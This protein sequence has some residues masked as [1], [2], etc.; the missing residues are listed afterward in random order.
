M[1]EDV[2]TAKILIVSKGLGDLL[3]A[4]FSGIKNKNLSVG[5]DRIN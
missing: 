5:A 4:I 2:E 1:R 3:D